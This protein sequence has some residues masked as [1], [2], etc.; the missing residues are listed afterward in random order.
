M[1]SF[2]QRRG[3]VAIEY[4]S[5]Y[6]WV[7]LVGVTSMVLL[8]QMGAFSPLP[9]QK[10]Q[11]GF[12][13]II[14]LDWL[15]SVK[16]DKMN[17]FIKSWSG[18]PVDITNVTVYFDEGGNCSLM[19]VNILIKPD[20]NIMLTLNCSD[21]ITRYA[22]HSCYRANVAYF[23]TN[24]RS[25]NPEESKGKIRGAFEGSAVTMIPTVILVSP[26]GGKVL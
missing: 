13:Q 10:T 11:V 1:S 3:Q 16:S 22:E 18:D 23:Y 25:H 4:L 12:S 14:P 6:G 8:S 2:N 9:C 19:G 5:N 24:T 17:I 20:Q 15:V 21:E 26:L 7:I